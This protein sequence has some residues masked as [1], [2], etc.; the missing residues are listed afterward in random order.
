MH[1]L[2]LCNNSQFN[3]LVKISY[4]N[5]IYKQKLGNK[6]VH[7]ITKQK[8]VYIRYTFRMHLTI[9]P[10]FSSKVKHKSVMKI[11]QVPLHLRYFKPDISPKFLDTRNI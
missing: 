1:F 6:Q 11:P 5:K 10:L 4:F 9:I 7:F 3:I 8:L 2:E